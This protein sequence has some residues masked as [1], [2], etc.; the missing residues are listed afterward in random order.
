MDA[1]SV[2]SYPDL[3]DPSAEYARK[4]RTVTRGL[5][6]LGRNLAVLNP[7]RSGIAAWQ[8][9]SHKLCRWLVPF[10]LVGLL[11]ANVPLAARS[12]FYAAVLILQLLS[13]AAAFYALRRR[14]P[15]TGVLRLVSFFVL[16]NVSILHAWLDVLRGRQAVTWA[17]SRR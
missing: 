14:T 10:A 7:F 11:V 16:V 17:P 2:G 6:S 3:G 15:P 5:R 9:F 12:R 1:A 13:Y 4:V 8:V